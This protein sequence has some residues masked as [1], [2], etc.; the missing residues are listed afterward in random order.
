MI[1][2]PIKVRVTPRH[3][4]A[5]I[6]VYGNRDPRGYDNKIQIWLDERGKLHI[7]MMKANLCY[8]FERVVENSSF[9]EVI[10]G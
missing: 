10:A 5:E 7:S 9:I 3:N 8:K 1:R 4:D 6:L 2:K